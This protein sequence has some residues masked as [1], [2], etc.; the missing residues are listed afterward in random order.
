MLYLA[1]G[2]FWGEIR[3]D[4][5]EDAHLPRAICSKIDVFA[6][7]LLSATIGCN[8]GKRA[9]NETIWVRIM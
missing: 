9:I 6:Y 5:M 1:V 2:G 8:I 7:G 3:C 4:M